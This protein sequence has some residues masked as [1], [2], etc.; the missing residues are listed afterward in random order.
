MFQSIRIKENP[1][2][3]INKLTYT[4]KYVDDNTT[5][6][7]SFIQYKTSVVDKEYDSYDG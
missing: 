2:E 6:E 1:P 5:S 4:I 7:L 3:I